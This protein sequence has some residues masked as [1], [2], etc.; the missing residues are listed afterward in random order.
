MTR[1]E[2]TL[3]TTMLLFA[4]SRNLGQAQ[5]PPRAILTFAGR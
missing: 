5:T 4:A 3:V 2:T 1:N